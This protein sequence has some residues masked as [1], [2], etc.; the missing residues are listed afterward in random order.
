MSAAQGF[1]QI[2]SF[3]AAFNEFEGFGSNDSIT[4]NG[5]T[6]IDYINAT[7]A[8][9]VDLQAGWATGDVSVGTDTI[10]GGVNSIQGSYYADTL[11]GSNNAPNT[12]E[13]YDGGAGDDTIDGRGGFDQA[14][15]N[16]AIA[17]VFGIDV[18]MGAGTVDGDASIGHDTL[19]SIESVRGTNFADT[20]DATGFGQPGALNIGNSATFNS[21]EGLAGNDTITGNGNTQLTFFNAGGG[22][23][24]SFSTGT[25]TG[26]ASVGTDHFTGVNNVQGSN[27]ND[28]II[29]TAGN[30]TFGGRGGA[31]T[32]VYAD[33]GGA[34]VVS[35]FSHGQGDKIDLTG[36]TGIYDLADVQAIA[37]QLGPNT[38]IDFGGSNTLTLNN[39]T[40]TNLAASDFIFAPVNHIVGDNND[41]I[42][43]GT[44][45]PDW[46]E[47][48]GGHDTLQGLAGDDVLDGGSEIDRAIYT[49]ATDGI[50]VDLAA[51]TAHGT[52]PGDLANVGTDTLVSIEQIGGSNFDDTYVATGYTGVSP[53]GSLQA[54]FNEFEGMAGDDIIT[55][56]GSTILLYL[57]ANDGVTVNFTSWVAGQGASGSA[58]GD[59]SVGT[60]T[61]TG[62]QGVRGSEFDDT[63][64]GSNQLTGVEVF[65]G[66]GGN[67]WIDGGGGFDRSN[68]WFRT[69][70]NVTGG[71]TVNLAAGTVVGDASVG[72]DTLRSIESV[73][74]TNFDDTYNAAGF[75]T[76]TSVSA[77]NAGNAGSLL[78]GS[79]QAAFNEFEGFD[80]DDSITGNGNTRIDYINATAAVTVDLAAGTAQGTAAGDIANVGLD[81]F[82]GVNSVQGSYFND[83]LYGSNNV[84]LT[85]KSFDGG[86]GNDFIDGRGGFDQAYYTN[87]IGTVQGIDVTVTTDTV[88]G[89]AFQ[90]VGDASIG[91]D[92]L[93]AIESVRGTNFVDTF[94]ATGYNG[95]STD[96]LPNG[97]HFNEF[98]GLG[99]NDVITG[100]GVTGLG[101][102][103][104]SY[105]SATAG[106]TVD[107]AAGIASGDASVGTDTITGG[108]NRVRGSNFNDTLSGD[109]NDNI[110]E[111]QNGN[112]ILNGR[113]GND[114]LTGGANSDTFVYTDNGGA[115]IVTDFFHAQADKINLIDV[116]GVDSL[117]AVQGIATQAGA[118]TVLDFGGGNT[119]TLNNVTAANLTASDF[120]FADNNDNILLGVPA[121][122]TLAGLGGNDTLTGGG[123]NDTLSGG[124]GADHFHYDAPTDGLDQ[125][126]DFNTAE[127]DLVEVLGAAFGGLSTGTLDPSLFST[128][129]DGSFDNTTERFSF[130]QVSH[131]LYYDGDGSDAGSTAVAIA[132][133]ATGVNITNHEI[134]V[135]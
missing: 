85:T 53:V 130:D 99:G 97:P 81:T 20:Y 40:A 127:G 52:A 61:F 51:G 75:T 46:I 122:E 13:S 29:G 112:D 79:F 117:A 92:T 96:V 128:Q 24:V 106:V 134:N 12:T 50:T 38:R 65:Q 22:V 26:D 131:T 135:V 105:V 56:N 110:L 115:D 16:N 42:L 109:A 25:V 47:G 43:V 95:A 116:T 62:V 1:F 55:G 36:V 86:A 41:N 93:I 132:Q 78:I 133:F 88:A 39:V 11:Y 76:T 68:Y 108:V 104:I 124:L 98:E 114:I 103:R 33:N 125:I 2:G 32:F 83:T 73:R 66:R 119:L 3:Q 15:Y 129:T 94:D 113:G 121:S 126:L 89:D 5:N 77:P 82:S 7:A 44:P 31:D 10:V 69:D 14:Y 72:T 90:V 107:L 100:N 45:S 60:D 74:A 71:I 118:H 35:D 9:T 19:R 91:I 6:R 101:A 67:D 34:D 123:G 63:F 58:I 57:N 8:V 23:T 27:F 18:D 87:A 111:G 70:D 120:I 49:N 28:T 102:T 17:T 30:Q 64:H 54:S 37:A 4:G 59:A 80:G 48:L 84:T 21:F